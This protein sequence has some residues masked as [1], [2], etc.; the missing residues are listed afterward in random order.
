MEL[1]ASSGT[2]Q[3]QLDSLDILGQSN[4]RD[5]LYTI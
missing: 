2:Q 4:T 3:Q 1:E 5:A